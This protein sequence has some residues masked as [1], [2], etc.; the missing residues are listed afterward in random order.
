MIFIRKQV[1]MSLDGVAIMWHVQL[2]THDDEDGAC[3][4]GDWFA[5]TWPQALNLAGQIVAQQDD[6]FLQ[7]TAVEWRYLSSESTPPGW[8][9]AYMCHTC[10]EAW[11]EERFTP[12]PA[13]HLLWHRKVLG[14]GRNA[15]FK[16]RIDRLKSLLR[17]ARGGNLAWVDIDEL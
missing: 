6:R 9:L 13:A 15:E 8:W 16:A 11:S 14:S 5:D 12:D 17:S 10:T 3:V 2:H 4:V 1:H 7:H